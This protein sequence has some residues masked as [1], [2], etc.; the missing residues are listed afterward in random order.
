MTKE[1]QITDT[2]T[3]RTLLNNSLDKSKISKEEL[4]KELNCLE[5]MT[6]NDFL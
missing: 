6:A 5:F 4:D 2:V 3:G 1:F